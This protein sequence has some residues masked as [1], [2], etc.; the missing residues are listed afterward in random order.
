MR[1]HTQSIL[2]LLLFL[3][4][5][6]CSTSTTPEATVPSEPKA[7]VDTPT[8]QQPTPTEA[9]LPTETPLPEPTATPEPFAC[10]IAFE[11]DRDGNWEVYTMG[12]D[13]SNPVNLSNYPGDDLDPAWSPDG[14]Q[15]AFVSNRE[16][17]LEGALF[18]YVMDA[19]GSNVRKLTNEDESKWPDWSHDGLWITYAYYGDIY[20]IKADGSGE[21][22]NLTNTPEVDVQP[23]WSPDGS[24]IA[25]LSGV[26]YAW[27]IFVMDAD[28]SNV[29]Q[30]TDNGQPGSVTWTIDGRILSDAWGWNDQEEFCHNCVVDAD[31]ANIVDA[32]GKGTLKEYVPFWTVDGQRVEV[33]HPDGDE[34]YLVGDIFPDVFFNLTNNPAADRNPD[35]P[36]NCG[37]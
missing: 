15:I 27:N 21:S 11:T 36:A 37:P 33:A 32:G 5:T 13:G 14:K 29:V 30:I 4:F 26:D 1:K 22:I 17:G 8:V 31:G 18:I 16:S 9:P 23:T 3:L 6:S 20:I 2:T 34:I 35:W 7:E 12:P 19:D 28:G 10:T 24:K 25:F